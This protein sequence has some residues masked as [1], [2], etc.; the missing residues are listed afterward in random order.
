MIHPLLYEVNT[1]CWLHRL[2]TEQGRAVT[3]GDVPDEEIDRWHTLGFTHIWAM[4]VW[5]VGPRCR[6]QALENPFL[7]HRFN[8]ILPGWRKDDVS[9]SPYAI[10]DY[11]VSAELGGAAGLKSFRRQLNARGMKLLLDF[12][13]NH[14]GLDHRWVNDKPEMFVQSPKEAPGTFRQMTARGLRHVAHGKDPHFP[15]WSDTVQLDYRREETQAAMLEILRHVS[16]QCDGVRCD[17]AMLELA[18]VFQK[19]WSHFPGPVNMPEGEF[20]TKAIETVRRARSD[21]LFLAEVYWGLEPKLQ[22]LGFNYTYAKTIYDRLV[23]KHYAGLQKELLLAS[24]RYLAHSVHFLENHDE[25]R[26]ADIFSPA[27][28]RA[29]ALLMLGLPGMRMIYEGQLTGARIQTPVHL[30]RWPDEPVDARISAMYEQLFL[31]LKDSAVGRGEFQ[32]LAP[33]PVA[34]DSDANAFIVVQWQK[35]SR[36]F[37]LVVVNLSA[38]AAQCIVHP[39]IADIAAHDWEAGDQLGTE[40]FRVH[41]GDVEGQGVRLG[42]PA[43]GAQLLRFRAESRQ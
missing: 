31:V 35:T 33:K 6:A 24:P 10:A 11:E 40:I 5:T 19:T 29:A 13:P 26:A 30:S 28:H 14:V 27:E 16:E 8:Q 4:G 37:E 17:M 41:G 34:E 3:L 32:L 9:G 2:S 39:A 12:V 18:E 7:Q 21:F 42:L 22:Q 43:H 25:R 36:E 15:P 23:D 1:R 20:W 38:K